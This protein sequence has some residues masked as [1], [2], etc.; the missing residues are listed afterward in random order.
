MKGLRD[1]EDELWSPI[2]ALA[3]FIDG[4]R[5]SR[6]PS[7]AEA[8]LLTSRMIRLAFTCRDRKQEDELEDNPEQ[9]ILAAVVD[10][11]GERGPILGQDEKPTDFNNSDDVL[12][13]VRA[14]DTLDWV[15]K[16]YLGKVLSRLQIIKDKK[17]DKP[18]LRV[19]SNSLVSCGRQ[20]LCYRLPRARVNDVAERYL[21]SD[22]VSETEEANANDDS[23]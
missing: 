15:K 1:R 23:Q 7:I 21:V 16:R 8:D 5:L 10:F 18:Y 6:D 22:P 17:K 9:R 20:I 19:E 4:R 12:E 3:E 14:R 11:I 2:F 13:Y